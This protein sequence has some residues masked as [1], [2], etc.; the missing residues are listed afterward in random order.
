MRQTLHLEWASRK[1]RQAFRNF[2]G[3]ETCD[4]GRPMLGSTDKG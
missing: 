3:G 4:R 2:R 1:Y